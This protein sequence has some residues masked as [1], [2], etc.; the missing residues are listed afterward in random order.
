MIGDIVV[1]TTL[2][3]MAGDHRAG[4]SYLRWKS[5]CAGVLSKTRGSEPAYAPS[6]MVIQPPIPSLKRKSLEHR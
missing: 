4:L 2:I 5:I 1:L 3:A 6:A